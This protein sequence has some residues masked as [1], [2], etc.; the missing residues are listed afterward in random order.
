[1][2]KAVISLDPPKG[3]RS[4]KVVVD[5]PL[6]LRGGE[7]IRLTVTPRSG[8]PWIHVNGSL[9]GAAPPPTPGA[10]RALPPGDRR[11]FAFAAVNNQPAWVYLNSVHAGSYSLHFDA[12]WKDPQKAAM[13]L[14]VEQGIPHPFKLLMTLLILGAVPLVIAVYQLIFEA[15]RWSESNVK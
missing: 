5:H 15:R 12:T 9:D 10:A 6:E 8:S 11:P 14:R 7:N 13:E 1:V 4:Q 2:L 3:Q